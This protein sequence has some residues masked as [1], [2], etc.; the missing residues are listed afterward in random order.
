MNNKSAISYVMQASVAISLLMTLL[1]ANPSSAQRSDLGCNGEAGFADFDF[2]VGE[3]TVFDVGTGEQ[4]GRNIIAKEEAGCMLVERWTSSDGVTGTSINY[5][6]PVLDE[7]RQVWISAGRYSI[8]MSGGL[9]DGIMV[10]TG[11]AYYY[12]GTQ[13][14]IRGSWSENT[15]GSVRQFFE[16]KNQSDEWLP[17]FEGRYVLQN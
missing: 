15:D 14:D 4:V 7:W 9:E 3:W 13:G 16:Q 10:L 2:W 5:Y 12:N 6:N 1:L 17:W 8:D 11:T